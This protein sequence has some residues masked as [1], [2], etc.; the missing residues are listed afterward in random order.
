MTE[1]L[2]DTYTRRCNREL[3]QMVDRLNHVNF[4][5]KDPAVLGVYKCFYEPILDST[6]RLYPLRDKLQQCLAS[7]SKYENRL[8]KCSDLILEVR[9]KADVVLEGLLFDDLSSVSK[10]QDVSKRCK[11]FERESRRNQCHIFP[12]NTVCA[13]LKEKAFP[14]ISTE[15]CGEVYNHVSDCMK[16]QKDSY[17]FLAILLRG[18]DQVISNRMNQLCRQYQTHMY[19]CFDK[20]FIAATIRSPVS[21]DGLDASVV[22]NRRGPLDEN[23]ILIKQLYAKEEEERRTN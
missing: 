18:R 5:E 8:S 16:E 4:N 23:Q 10:L 2:N 6:K 3:R 21:E 19:K 11:D 1:F 20:Y 12:E 17:K 15:A 13:Q 7:N 9:D 14:C 22:V